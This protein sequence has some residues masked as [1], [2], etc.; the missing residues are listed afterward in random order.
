MP[1]ILYI[2]SNLVSFFH[3]RKNSLNAR[4][5]ITN[6]A[7]LSP[8]GFNEEEQQMASYLRDQDDK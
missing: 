2:A 5:S 8:E 7:A 3:Q 6:G 4:T 1:I